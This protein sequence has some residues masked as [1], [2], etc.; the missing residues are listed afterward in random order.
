M[1]MIAW[2]ALILWPMI[3]IVFFRKLSLP[4][5]LCVTILG[6]Y[7]LLPSMISLNLPLLPPL[8][9]SSIAALT[10][11]VLTF[12]AVANR[13]RDPAVLPGWLPRSPVVLILFAVLLIGVFGS[14]QTNRDTLV[15]GGKVLPGLRPYD[16]FSVLL[17]TGVTMVPLFLGRKLLAGQEGQRILFLSLVVSA[18]IYTVP[19]LYEVRMSPQFHTMVYGYFPSQFAQSMRDGGFRPVV[20]LNH[21][22]GLAIYL[23]F[24]LLA[25]A[26]LFRATRGP[27]RWKWILAMGWLF[28]VLVLT[29]T[30]GALLIALVLL[31]VALFLRPRLQLIAAACIAGMIVS[32]PAMRA[33]DV[34]PIE[35]IM[36]FA[37][38]INP[39]RARSL[40]TRIQNE[41]AL[42]EKAQQRPLFGW[43]GWGRNRI[44][45]EKGNNLTVSDGAW[46][47]ALGTGG[48]FRYIAIFGVLSWPVFGLLFAPREKIDVLCSVLALILCAKLVDLVPNSGLPPFLML[49]S[50]ALLGRLEIRLDEPADEPAQPFRYARPLRPAEG[51][52]RAAGPRY[53]RDFPRASGAGAPAAEPRSERM[54]SRSRDTNRLRPR[55]GPQR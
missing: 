33:A 26:G 39:H 12:F 22:L 27:T 42:L 52:E 15:Y 47:I 45:D 37:H 40:N 9:K 55:P 34:I 38:D 20:F 17:G 13:P 48:W 54:S 18:L 3:S 23:T 50:G 51:D 8:N 1:I 43:G 24:A 4:V 32:Y 5:A 6:G 16:G 7:L 14:V 49:M 11:L 36:S 10:A 35:K 19:A 21:G 41:D 25:A 30:L 46:I 29:K 44:F 28:L 31:P 53:A 2:G